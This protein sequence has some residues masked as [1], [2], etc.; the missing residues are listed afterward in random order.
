[1][2]LVKTSRFLLVFDAKRF[3][4]QPASTSFECECLSE[5]RNNIE[6]TFLL[7]AIW[8]KFHQNRYTLK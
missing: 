1:M 7:L 3:N 5:F 8:R 4:F 6:A 2:L